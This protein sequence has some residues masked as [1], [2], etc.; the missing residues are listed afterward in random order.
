M[1]DENPKKSKLSWPKTL[2]K[3]WFNIKS[4]GRERHADDVADRGDNRQWTANFSERETCTVKRSSTDRLSR[5]HIDQIQQGTFDP[6]SAQ[7]ADVQDYK[8]FVATW[9]VGGKSPPR[10]L[11]LLDW[12]HSSSPS[13]IYVLGFQ[14]IVPLNAGNVLVTED[15]GP[16]KKWLWLI[17]KTLN[18]PDTCGSDSYHTPSPVPYPIL[19]LNADFERF[20]VRQKNSSLLHRRSFQYPSHSLKFEGDTI[21]PQQMIERRFSVCDR[22]SFES[23]P[24]DFDS[25][26]RYEGS[27]DD[28]NIGEQSPT[29]MFSSPNSYGYGAPPHVEE[30][31]RL[32]VNSRYCMVASKQMVGIFLTIWVR[33][34]IREDIKNL[35][36]SCVG[37]GLMGYLGNKGSISISMSFHK[38]SFCFICSHLTSGQKDGD[39]LRRNSD[40]MEILKKTRF[41]HV[42]RSDRDKSPETI[43]DHD[44]IIWLG[45]LN[46]R[47]A[48]S[49][50]SVKTLVEMRNWRALLEKDQLQIEQ[51]C[52]RVFEGWKEGRI[53]FPPTYKYSNNSDR[54]AGDDTNPKE[55]RRTP[56]W[57]D[58]IL[59]HGRG[60]NQLSY[61]RGESRFSDHRPVYSIFV[62][63]VEMMNHSYLRKNMGY[64]GSRVEAEELLP[65]SHGYTEHSASL[66][67]TKTILNL[68][69]NQHAVLQIKQIGKADGSFAAV[70]NLVK[71]DV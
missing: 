25:N 40:V 42:Q 27:S 26:F 43:L 55:K 48:L 31:D 68:F 60:L 37:R 5:K 41:P 71:K 32:S 58:R 12:L 47:I 20:S 65:H 18:S 70:Q 61:V 13:D 28:E 16:A 30:R 23:R 36:I 45:D 4:K 54:Y 29:D 49:Y 14:E 1:R 6:H 62:A 50:R 63:E 38:T 11:I 3:R 52:G 69:G 15:N 34:D 9:N 51:R 33:S 8:I 2:V 67:T 59:W 21:L 22:V 66:Q 24:S 46:Y 35:K 57:C 56:A 19:E 17:R 44:R 39:E 64:F 53:Y 7:V 10:N